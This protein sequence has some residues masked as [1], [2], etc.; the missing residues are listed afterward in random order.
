MGLFRSE[1]TPEVHNIDVTLYTCRGCVGLGEMTQQ[2]MILHT[3]LLPAHQSLI[4]ASKV[5]QNVVTT[6]VEKSGVTSLASATNK[7]FKWMD[8]GD[9]SSAHKKKKR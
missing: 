5:Q 9:S 4:E 2:Q 6:N 8:S 1:K 7:L 3:R